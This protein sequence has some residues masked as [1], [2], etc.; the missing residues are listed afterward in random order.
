M[1]GSLITSAYVFLVVCAFLSAIVIAIRS[2]ARHGTT[3]TPAKPRVA[4]D[5]FPD[6]APA[7]PE[8]RKDDRLAPPPPPRDDQEFYH[9]ADYVLDRNSPYSIPLPPRPDDNEW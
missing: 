3:S 7:W 5:A 2:L 9:A 4:T 1:N 6:N 8:A